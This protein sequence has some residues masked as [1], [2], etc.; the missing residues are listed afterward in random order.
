Q[1]VFVAVRPRVLAAL[2]ARGA[3]LLRAR[4][5]AI[6]GALRRAGLRAGEGPYSGLGEARSQSQR[7]SP[8]GSQRC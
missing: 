2:R 3:L 7:K 8:D 5:A 4:P 6:S 1:S